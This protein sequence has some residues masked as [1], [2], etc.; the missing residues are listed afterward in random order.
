MVRRHRREITRIAN[1]RERTKQRES[2]GEPG[3]REKG[4]RRYISYAAGEGRD[5]EAEA[6]ANSLH[7]QDGARRGLSLYF[8]FACLS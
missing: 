3:R 2:K 6:K 5:E 4:S 1:R 7:C 8:A